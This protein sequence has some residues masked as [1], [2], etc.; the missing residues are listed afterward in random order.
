VSGE[1]LERYTFQVVEGV[2]Y[3]ISTCDSFTGDPVVHVTGACRCDN[4]NSCGLG[5][6][7][8]CV[9]ES[10][11]E[12]TICAS[13]RAAT[14]ASWSYT[15]TSSSGRCGTPTAC[16]LPTHACDA[17][18]VC[19][20]V[21]TSCPADG[22][23]PD[24][25]LCDDNNAC[26]SNDRCQSGACAPGAAVSCAEGQCQGAFCDPA[27]GR[28]VAKSDG[29]TCDD[30]D[31]GSRDDLCF[32]G[33]CRG[34]PTSYVT[35]IVAG[36]ENSFALTE[37]GRLYTFGA[38]LQATDRASPMVLPT[39]TRVI[40]VDPVS[41]AAA[42]QT[43]TLV[44]RTDGT[45][46]AWGGN[47]WG[48]L[49]DGTTT[50]S[51]T[52][53]TPS[54]T[55]SV[56][57]VAA[58]LM[59]S[60][61][62]TTSGSL[63]VWGGNPYGQLGDGGT[64]AQLRPVQVTLPFTPTRIA[65]GY[66]HALA[67]ASDGAVWAWGHNVA[68]QVGDGTTTHRSTPVR[69]AGL[70]AIT[71]IAAGAFHSLALASDGSVWAWGYNVAG[72]LGDG[73]TVNRSTPVRVGGISAADAIAAG[74]VH[75]LAVQTGGTLWGWG[76]SGQ[77]QLG[78]GGAAVPG[79]YDP[80][81]TPVRVGAL[82]GIVSIAAGGN[83]TLAET[84]EG[85][86]WSLGSNANGQLGD[87]TA[88]T[89]PRTRMDTVVGFGRYATLVLQQGYNTHRTG[90]NTRETALTTTN[91]RPQTFGRL[92]SA[93][94]DGQVHAQPLFVGGAIN[95]DDVLY[96]ATEQNTLY[97]LDAS[98]GA[99]IWSRNYGVPFNHVIQR[100]GV[101]PCASSINPV[102]GITSTPA[103]DLATHT[104]YFVAKRD[105]GD[106]PAVPTAGA[107][108]EL[109]AVDMFSGADRAGSP[110]R[111]QATITRPD[112]GAADGTTL[113]MSTSRS[114][115]FDPLRHFQRPALLLQDGQLWI[116]FGGTCDILPYHGWVMTYDARTLAPSGAWVSSSVG[117]PAC[118]MSAPTCVPGTPGSFGTPGAARCCA[119]GAGIWS[120]GRGPASTGTGDVYVTTGNTFVPHP[121]DGVDMSNAVVRLG[122]APTGGVTVRD[123][124]VPWNWQV[125]D[126]YDSDLSSAGV[127]LIPNTN[128]LLATG[129]S[130]EIW[131]LNASNLGHYTAPPPTVT[132][133]VPEPG[134]LQR[135]YFEGQNAWG[136]IGLPYN[137][138]VFWND[139]AY[140]W[141][142]SLPVMAWP[143]DR[144]T[145]TFTC[146]RGMSFP[147]PRVPICASEV[148]AASSAFGVQR[149]N[150][151]V[152][153]DGARAGTGV[154]WS[155]VPDCDGELVAYDAQNISVGP[156]Y[157]S[158]METSDHLGRYETMA[159]PVVARGLV[160]VPT[161]G[162]V[163]AYGLLSTPRTTLTPHPNS[164][165][166][167]PT[168]TLPT[169]F[170][171]AWSDLYT[172]YFGPSVT[173]VPGATVGCQGGGTCHGT[174][175]SASVHRMGS[176][177]Q[178]LYNYWVAAG[179]LTP[180]SPLNSPIL[181]PATSRLK[182]VNLAA[183]MPRNTTDSCHPG[184]VS[185]LRAWIEDWD[186]N[187][188]RGPLM[189][190]PPSP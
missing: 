57:Q 63:W 6:R 51:P 5:A 46:R 78:R 104:I 116:A 4:D 183:R 98:S 102:A 119:S 151:T 147:D 160:F 56:S 179:W 84:W 71:Q 66:H 43:H 117:D 52:P 106:N 175:G 9:A 92:Y 40:G 14:A 81:T 32:G 29:T 64:S 101:E 27:T 137:G 123:W 163:V 171:P 125:L 87:D 80:Q 181:N 99:V 55:G 135:F 62:L 68:G 73:T 85:R 127:T 129:K 169:V 28:C 139:R 49:G 7:C 60:M 21:S 100:P 152:S 69:V 153:A 19:D 140:L 75:S 93:P 132:G 109:H 133:P 136:N 97:A 148:N 54:I 90:A 128:L 154:L 74:F 103:I 88:G 91:V 144:A 26:T 158:R 22:A 108:F 89:P 15:V 42:A 113:P 36:M 111:I 177:P 11:G 180:T 58:G 155:T 120:S 188:T 67:L 142:S 170:T 20:G 173:S 174:A 149:T 130:A 145:S 150:I 107:A 105:T 72:Q 134:V 16:R 48:Q 189:V 178:D 141:P 182:W 47:T 31:V 24:G 185:D 172:R 8:T 159:S 53:V 161:R 39:P 187:R 176:T 166:M 50:G 165:C 35:R 13:S 162:A 59:F 156:I 186:R 77:G 131:V 146:P 37:D 138:T 1:C 124:Y 167:C 65:A 157:T 41:E 95:G 33:V 3:T 143:L 10:S 122:R 126:A 38:N 45:V 86:I 79:V 114:L 83:H 121:P 44:A 34:A 17:A 61:A 110:V 25:T 70:P 30:G 96:V 12:A 115:V 112:V 82:G 18:E 2:T 118:V 190:P 94:V 168:A 184:A 76:D 164:A 23:E